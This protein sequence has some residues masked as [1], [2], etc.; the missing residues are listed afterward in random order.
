ME[1]QA[2]NKICPADR[3]SGVSEYYFSKKLKEV[4]QM[5]A[6]GKNVTIYSTSG[7]LVE[8]IDSY[9]GEEIVLDKGVYIVRVGNKT[10]KVKL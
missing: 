4:A 8:K 7:A 2:T 3:L 9:A 5:N 6:E 10:M 1:N